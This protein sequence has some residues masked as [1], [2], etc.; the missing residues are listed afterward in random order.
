MDSRR[1]LTKQIND[2]RVQAR[3]DEIELKRLKETIESD[4]KKWKKQEE[5]YYK[6]V[7][8]HRKIEVEAGYLRD[9]VKVL[10]ENLKKEQDLRKNLQLDKQTLQGQLQT[11]QTQEQMAQ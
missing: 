8:A 6:L 10:D 4:K 5:V 7:D 1:S 11:I 9:D 2:L 3:T